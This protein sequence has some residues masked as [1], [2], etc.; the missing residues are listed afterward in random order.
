MDG[1]VIITESVRIG[2]AVVNTKFIKWSAESSVLDI[3][4]VHKLQ[5]FRYF[6]KLMNNYNIYDKIYG[7]CRRFMKLLLIHFE[8]I[9]RT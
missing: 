6:S 4:I 2:H 9:P 1:H 8:Q 5:C 3:V 7:F